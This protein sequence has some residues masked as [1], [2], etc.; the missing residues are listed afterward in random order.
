MAKITVEKKLNDL[1]KALMQM[2][3]Q[4]RQ[5][6]IRF[7]AFVDEMKVF[8]NEMADFKNEM[9]DFKNEM[10]DFKDETRANLSKLDQ[11]TADMNR[12]WGELANKMGTLAEDIVAPGFPYLIERSFGISVEDIAVRR[13]IKD[14]DG[15]SWE[16]DVVARAGDYFFVVDIKSSYNRTEYLDYFQN[17][18]LSKAHELLPEFKMKK[19]RLLG[20]IA[21]FRLES[22]I[23]KKASDMGIL[24][25]SM[26]GNYLDFLNFEEVKKTF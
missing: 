23:I 4:S 8:K 16:F 11:I 18:L 1:E 9:K 14:P 3:Y 20:C 5:T 15:N 13:R 26:G 2:V 19:Y 7:A 24:A 21:A 22:S 12:K 10:A 25:I 17:T 6:D